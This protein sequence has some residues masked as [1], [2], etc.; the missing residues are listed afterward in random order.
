MKMFLTILLLA[1]LFLCARMSGASA[2]SESSE[3]RD[4]S[5][6]DREEIGWGYE[7]NHGNEVRAARSMREL[8]RSQCGASVASKRVSKKKKRTKSLQRIIGGEEAPANAY[9]WTVGLTDGSR[10]PF[11]G[12]T[13]ISRKHV[14]TAAHCVEGTRASRLFVLTGTNDWSPDKGR[15]VRAARVVT[16]PRYV[17]RGLNFDVAVI[18]LA[19][20]VDQMPV[21]IPSKT[22]ANRVLSRDGRSV[23]VAGWGLTGSGGSQPTVLKEVDVFVDRS[24]GTYPKVSLEQ[25]D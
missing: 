20:A 17:A 25:S 21:C 12:G 4:I 2:T 23:K 22:L 19:I 8:R 13:L 10:R 7:F 6:P 15:L 1:P 11:C 14:V 3:V 16:H 18:T 24:C 9:P 5:L